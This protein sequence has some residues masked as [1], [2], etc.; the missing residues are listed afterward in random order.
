MQ[1]VVII[2]LRFYG[3]PNWR[4]VLTNVIYSC[5]LRRMHSWVR[6]YEALR[7]SNS[8]LL[9][10]MAFLSCYLRCSPCE[11]CI[12]LAKTT[13]A[14]AC[15]HFIS[16]ISIWCIWPL[17]ALLIYFLKCRIFGYMM[18]L[19]EAKAVSLDL[20]GGYNKMN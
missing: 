16:I 2:F 19:E 12:L 18:S 15:R 10:W 4:H 9:P 14:C 7:K 8:C 5:F 1:D 17:L 20:F 3:P 11:L 6:S 13:S